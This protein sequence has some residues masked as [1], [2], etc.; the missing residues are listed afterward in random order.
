MAKPQHPRG[1]SRLGLS[2]GALQRKGSRSRLDD[3]AIGLKLPTITDEQMRAQL[4]NAQSYTLMVLKKTSRY[5]H[6]EADTLVWEHGRRN[7]GLR[8]AGL[9]AIVCPIVDSSEY[10]GIGIFGASPEWVSEIMNEDPGVKAGVF[11]F[12]IYAIVGFPG[13]A[14][15]DTRAPG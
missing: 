4:A 14:L 15:P 10:A 12:E 2:K 13:S 5:S 11:A 3:R 8:E 7:F 9:M 1:T 6:P